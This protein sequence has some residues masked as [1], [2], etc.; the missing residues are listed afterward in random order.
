MRDNV[1]LTAFQNLELNQKLQ[2][3]QWRNHIEIRRWM[4]TQEIIKQENHLAFIDSL[5]KRNDV[6]YWLVS[7]DD[8]PTGV[9]SLT[10]INRIHLRTDGGIYLRPDGEQKGMGK[11]LLECMCEQAFLVLGLHSLRLEALAANERANRFY[12]RFGFVSEGAYRDY[13]RLNN[14]EYVDVNIYS[15]TEK[16]YENR[17]P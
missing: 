17:K 9:I 14:D 15:I 2:I 11:L 13:V 6:F 3:L 7:V 10:G 5:T 8:V 12:K 4:Y 16:D 1:T